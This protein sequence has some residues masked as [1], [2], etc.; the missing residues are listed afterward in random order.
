MSAV[1]LRLGFAQEAVARG[2]LGDALASLETVDGSPAGR[3]MA[4]D[5]RLVAV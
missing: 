4:A 2:N 3:R 1:S 5:A